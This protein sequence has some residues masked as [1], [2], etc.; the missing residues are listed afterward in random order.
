[1]VDIKVGGPAVAATERTKNAKRTG[2]TGGPSFAS[3]LTDAHAPE[4]TPTSGI[5]GLPS[6]YIPLT[7][8]KDDQPHPRNTKERTQGLIENLQQLAEDVMA[9]GNPADSAQKL[10]A[11]LATSTDDE[12]A[13]SPAAREA[14]QELSTRAAVAAAKIKS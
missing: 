13:L 5:T 11:Y 3:L 14:I 7:N 12:A 10:E 4:T 6:G 9:G 8:D 1:M 2:P